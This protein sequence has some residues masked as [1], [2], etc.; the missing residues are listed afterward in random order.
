VLLTGGASRRMG[1]DKATFAL[2]GETL[3]MHAAGVLRGV[4]DPVV[5]V[6]P[7][8]TTLPCVREQPEGQGP[9]AALLAGADALAT[10]GPIVV[11]ACDLPFIAEPAV[12]WLADYH[13]PG[14]VVPVIGGREQYSC[15]RW[16]AVA[17][18]HGRAAYARGE[19]ALRTLVDAGDTTRAAA[20]EHATAFADVDTP[21]DLRRLGLS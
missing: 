3:A 7:G 2:D 18:A 12:R 17:I 20:D 8:A 9:L 13:A 11:L 4:C 15:A 6:G 14:S 10:D 19:R 21:G 5:E 16:S 1:F